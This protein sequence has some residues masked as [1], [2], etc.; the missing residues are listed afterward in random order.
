MAELPLRLRDLTWKP[1][2]GQFELGPISLDIPDGK[3]IALL[4]PNG[5]GKSSL[6]KLLSG[7][8]KPSNGRVDLFGKGYS[9]WKPRERGRLVAFLPQESENPFGFPLTEYV[10]LGRFPHLGALGRMTMEDRRIVDAEINAW[11]LEKLRMR[12]V[13]NLSGGEFQR[14]RLAR[15]FAQQPRILLFDEPA[16]HLD[17]LSKV[18]ILSRLKKEAG[19]GRCVLAAIHD[20][21][22]AIFCADE[23]WLLNNGR[24]LES[25][26][27]SSVLKP[28]RLADIYGIELTRFA[29]ADGKMMFG[30]PSESDSAP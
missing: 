22:D 29:S 23:I 30:I 8:L 25:G 18:R 2:F 3:I 9:M 4:G 19:G 1:G 14:A 5:V 15:A 11:G 7:I 6:L 26:L 21:N 13:S 27:P 17:L 24:V 16:S 20:V 28:S 12:S 10:S